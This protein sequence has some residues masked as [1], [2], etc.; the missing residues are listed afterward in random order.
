MPDYQTADIRNIAVVGGT[1]AGK[2]TLIEQMLCNAGVIG[3]AGKVEDGNTVCD[4]D[5]LS[6]EFGY[7]LD[8]SIVHFD[9]AGHHVNVIDTPGNPDFLGKAISV[10]P[11]VETACVVIDAQTGV[12]SVARRMMRIAADRRLPRMIVINKI[13][14]VEDVAA[15]LAAVQ[16]AFG[17]VCLPLNL[18]AKGGT[19][20]V[21]CF[22]NA[23]G[24][25][26]LG[27]VA[28]FHSAIVDQVVEVDEE[29]MA[30]YLEEG[31]VS[32]EQ[33]HAPF[34]KALREAHLVPVCF[35]SARDNVGVTKLKDIFT[36]LC[37][38]PLEGNPRRFEYLED[39]EV[40][41]IEA[42]PDAEAP[43][44]AHVFKV[45]FDPF[46]GK[47]AVFRV[48]QGHIG[49]DFQPRVGDSRKGVRIA[50]AFKL[51]GKQHAEADRLIAGDIGAVAKIDDINY[52]SVLHSEGMA[53]D[54][55]LRPLPLPRPMYGLAVEAAS[56]GAES[57]LA[58]ALQK[59]AA[60][61][62]TIAVERVQSTGETVL[63]GLGEQHLR[64]KLRMLET[65][66]NLDVVTK[67]PRVPYKETITVRAE[68]HCRHKKQTGGAGQFGEVYLR[69]APLAD[70]ETEKAVD[71]LLFV[72]ET[73]GG[74]IPRQFLPAVEKGVRQV[75][76]SGA[77]AGYPMQNVKVT[78]YDG[79][80]HS[81]DSK[82]VAFITAGRKAFI[83][84][85]KKAKPVLLEP[86]VKLE[87]AIPSA[88]IGDVSA[89]L[90]G[91]RGRI[92]GTDMRT[93]DGAVMQAEAP[94]A[95]F[96]D[97][98]S[99]LKS[100]TSGVGTYVMEYSHDEPAPPAVQAQ[101]VA[102]YRPSD[103]ED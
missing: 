4:H 13:D 26:D 87:I 52:N 76:Q 80:H 29:L 16:E 34:E 67:P 54:L 84:G 27:D 64:A 60:E 89:D 18:P 82:E 47:M 48:H 19:A 23:T 42:V 45:A 72:D 30:V 71:G 12:D 28:G 73:V 9:H 5:D 51:Q 100:M 6:K 68:G 33:L 2:T 17:A 37:P 11:A 93:G 55:H 94:L 25:S 79:K 49:H 14:H 98:A 102:A 78:V 95:E 70:G 44:I 22:A 1:A 32:P 103:D 46:V 75:M 59:L 99:H 38:S 63:R 53:G 77:V 57:R 7:S 24:D 41:R 36:H 83:E 74:S 61:D 43:L 92:L 66:Y 62:P 101:V 90:S 10:L 35:T 81:V 96:M 40:R 15:T 58:D 69:V 88:M 21:D 8:S 20:V 85:V 91:K 56:T 50:H 86:F 97:Y 3:R 31:E 39:G 65:R